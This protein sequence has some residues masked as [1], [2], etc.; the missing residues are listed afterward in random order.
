MRIAV[1]DTAI[2]MSPDQVKRLFQ[3][4]VQASSE[5]S[6]R[7]GGAGLGLA[8]TRR[9]AML[10][11]GDV[12]V[13]S[14]PGEGSVFEL[15]VAARLGELAVDDI[16]ATADIQ[17]RCVLVIEDG[18]DSR[19]IVARAATTLGLCVSGVTRGH[20]GLAQARAPPSVIVF[21]IGRP[22][23][24]DW[25]ILSALKADAATRDVA[26]IVY[27]IEDDRRTS[28]QLGACERLV[29]PVDRATLAAAIARFAFG[30]V[31]VSAAAGAKPD[32]GAQT[33]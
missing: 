6:S 24:S 18:A 20:E 33:A 27:S 15:T 10:M 7:F 31:A 5:T 29:K 14:T 4:F 2:G 26:V 13:R 28:L 12:A 11:G 22:H 25:S 30:G 9:L 21:D 1:T 3:P 32:R 17:G 19:D 16:R 23:G 8:V